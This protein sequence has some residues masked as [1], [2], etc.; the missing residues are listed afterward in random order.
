MIG[1]EPGSSI[2]N[3]Y[4][5]GRIVDSD[6][7]YINGQFVGTTS[8]QYPPRKYDVPENVLKTGK[9]II[10]FFNCCSNTHNYCQIKTFGDS[11]DQVFTE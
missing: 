5:L 9:K 3:W 8:Y 2:R 4:N 11:V 1:W 6:S 10:S 7:I